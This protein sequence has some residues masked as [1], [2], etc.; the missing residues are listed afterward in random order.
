VNSCAR[1]AAA[2]ADSGPYLL[3]ALPILAPYQPRVSETAYPADEQAFS[4]IPNAAPRHVSI[5]RR[6]RA[7]IAPLPESDA[8]ILALDDAAEVQDHEGLL[9]G[10]IPPPLKAHKPPTKQLAPGSNSARTRTSFAACFQASTA[11]AI[12]RQPRRCSRCSTRAPGSGGHIN[13]KASTSTTRL[14]LGMPAASVW[15]SIARNAALSA[16]R[17]LPLRIR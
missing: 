12:Q 10:S 15:V 5:R 8:L 7:P 4:A 9:S 13:R 6:R 3:P 11:A 1:T 17:E 14:R 2:C 16:L